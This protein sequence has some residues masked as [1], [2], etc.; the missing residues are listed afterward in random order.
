[1]FAGFRWTVNFNVVLVVQSGPLVAMLNY[2]RF[3]E[4]P[5]PPLERSWQVY[6]ATGEGG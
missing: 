1:V 3:S 5:F 2:R 4:D 6:L